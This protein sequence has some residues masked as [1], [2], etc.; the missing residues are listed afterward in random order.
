M[1]EANVAGLATNVYS[2]GGVVTIASGSNFST[3][4]NS[5]WQTSALIW[6]WVFEAQFRPQVPSIDIGLYTGIR[7]SGS[8]GATYTVQYATAL[9]K[10]DWITLTNVTLQTPQF[11]YVDT[12]SVSNGPHRFY[13]VVP[14]P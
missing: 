1:S 7:I 9:T 6:D 13:R 11:L 2:G 4:T 8:I 12:N 5:D 14:T 10:T 3:L